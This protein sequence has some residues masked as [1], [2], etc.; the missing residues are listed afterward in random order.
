MSKYNKQLNNIWA[1]GRVA[2]GGRLYALL[3]KAEFAAHTRDCMMKT[4]LSRGSLNRQK[5]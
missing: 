5:C 2:K 1:D 4:R 3:E